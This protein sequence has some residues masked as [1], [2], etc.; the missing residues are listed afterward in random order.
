MIILVLT[1]VLLSS[2]I[3]YA[4]VDFRSGQAALNEMKREF[5]KEAV[6][7]ETLYHLQV[8]LRSV[9]DRMPRS[10]YTQY[11]ED[12]VYQPTVIASMWARRGK[13]EV[14]REYLMKAEHAL[15]GAGASL[16]CSSTPK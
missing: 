13:M 6:E 1:L 5:Q 3:C 12:K 8:W 16:T 4:G 14:A 11:L 9:L 7:D 10:D 15:N 2:S